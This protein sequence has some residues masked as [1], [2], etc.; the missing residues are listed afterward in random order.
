MDQWIEL[1][2]KFVFYDHDILIYIQMNCTKCW[3]SAKL[4]IHSI[5]HK[6]ISMHKNHKQK[7]KKRWDE[8]I[9]NQ[10]QIFMLKTLSQSKDKFK[11]YN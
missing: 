2:L 9:I 4:L 6:N 1:N 8:I 3:Q 5:Y 11:C 7:N 10:T